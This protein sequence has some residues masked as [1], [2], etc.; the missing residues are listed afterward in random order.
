MRDKW[1]GTAKR[2]SHFCF[3]EG[4]SWQVRSRPPR[5]SVWHGT[6]RTLTCPNMSK[7]QCNLLTF[8]KVYI[9][10][11]LQNMNDKFDCSFCFFFFFTIIQ[12][13]I[14]YYLMLSVRHSK[15]TDRSLFRTKKGF[16]QHTSSRRSRISLLST[17]NLVCLTSHSCFKRP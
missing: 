12:L 9:T 15:R 8:T 3:H 5:F 2:I 17:T 1:S 4:P 14:T 11:S 10:F 16:A 7:L 6:A 13:I